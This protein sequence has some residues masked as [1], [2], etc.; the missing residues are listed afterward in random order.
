MY[1]VD[2]EN[3]PEHRPINPS[4]LV[5]LL[6]DEPDTFTK[7]AFMCIL[8]ASGVS[9]RIRDAYKERLDS[10]LGYGVDLSLHKRNHSVD[11]FLDPDDGIWT[12]VISYFD[13][14]GTFVDTTGTINYV[15]LN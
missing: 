12:Y 5:E 13:F 4:N 14:V 7:I 8:S 6:S 1:F 11:I 10:F 3:D 9:E 15:F 2:F